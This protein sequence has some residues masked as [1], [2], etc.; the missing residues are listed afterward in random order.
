MVLVH[1]VLGSLLKV[2]FASGAKSS[3]PVSVVMEQ[4][5]EEEIRWHEVAGRRAT[6]TSAFISDPSTKGRM[7]LLSIVREPL[8]FL[9]AAFLRAGARDQRRSDIFGP[10]RFNFGVRSLGAEWR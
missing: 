3:K 7:L 1:N 6:L 5:F 2:T 9:T 4:L 8:R 10:P